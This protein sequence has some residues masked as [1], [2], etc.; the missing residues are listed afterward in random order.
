MSVRLARPAL[1]LA[2]AAGAALAL[3]ASAAP[4][5]TIT[6]TD[7]KG[8]ANAINGQGAASG[9]GD[10]SGPIQ[11]A[12]SDLVSV[13]L[14]STGTTKKIKRKT[15]FTCTGFTATIELAAPAGAASVYRVLGKGIADA[16]Q[17]WLQYNAAPTGTTSTIRYND[18]AAKTAELATPAK[19]DGNK[20]TFV[21]TE[22]DLKAASEKLAT[23]TM[24]A[25]GAD[26]RTSTGAATVPSWDGIDT[27]DAKT[28]SPCK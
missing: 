9:A 8:D 16:S 19:L 15:V 11:K 17:F 1:L 28:F 25:L 6:L 24:S 13:T 23:F 7:V 20:I 2:L 12:D 26:V 10:H 5:N 4:P 21:V 27:D 14:A 18:G 3:P 22:A